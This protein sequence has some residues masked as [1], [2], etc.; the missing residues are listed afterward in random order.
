MTARCSAE[1]LARARRHLRR[2]GEMIRELRVD[3]DESSREY[4][5]V[6]DR[7]TRRADDEA[8]RAEAAEERCVGLATLIDLMLPYVETFAYQPRN[9]ERA[10]AIARDARAA[11]V[12]AEGGGRGVE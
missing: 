9:D 12:K 2:C 10:W 3:E 5:L 6:I 1:D 8:C 7:L 11:L 4:R